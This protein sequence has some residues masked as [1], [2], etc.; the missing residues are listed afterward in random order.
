MGGDAADAEGGVPGVAHRLRRPTF[1][2]SELRARPLES[3][4]Y[5][6]AQI[7]ASRFC[8]PNRVR[9]QR[10]RQSSGCRRAACDGRMP[11]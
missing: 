6:T 5:G 7:T 9:T 2:P 1:Y 11:H 4:T 3:I 8:Q 10:W